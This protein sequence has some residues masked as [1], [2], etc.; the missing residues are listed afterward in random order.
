[1]SDA[2]RRHSDKVQ[3]TTPENWPTCCHHHAVWAADERI[4]ITATVAAMNAMEL[5]LLPTV[6][7]SFSFFCLLLLLQIF[8]KKA[9]LCIDYKPIREYTSFQAGNQ[10]ITAWWVPLLC[11][12]LLYWFIAWINKGGLILPKEE[13]FIAPPFLTTVVLKSSTVFK[14]WEI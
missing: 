6:F 11:F 5:F 9:S 14:V 8:C 2:S 13:N 12:S 1:M 7:S 4:L 10:I 3:V